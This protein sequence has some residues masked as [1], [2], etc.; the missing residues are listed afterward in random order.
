MT[1]ILGPHLRF[2]VDPTNPGQFFAGLGLLEL[3][4][5]LWPGAEGWFENE[6]FVLRPSQ[7]AHSVSSEFSTLELISSLASAELS[8]VDLEDDCSS[9]IVVGAPFHL[10]LDWWLDARAGGARLKVWAG[11]MRSVR[12]AR[13]MQAAIPRGSDQSEDVFNY[14]AVVY[15]VVESEK[16]VEPYYFDSRRGASAMA[17]DVGFSTDSL[18]MKTTAYPAVEFLCLVGIQRY[19]PMPTKARRVFDYCT[20]SQPLDAQIA[21][22]A[23]CG[24]LPQVGGSRYR[25]ENAFR[26]DQRKHKA[27][28]PASPIGKEL[29]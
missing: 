11:S 4:D 26:T 25:F 29:P 5:R 8:Q 22:A 28:M 15:D 18:K 12:I 2:R 17:L 24:I 21:A 14:N 10:R 9:P 6:A 19:R 3:A 7:D 16:K 13:A 27:F 23:V 20:W 1:A